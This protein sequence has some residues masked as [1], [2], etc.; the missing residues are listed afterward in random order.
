MLGVL[1]CSLIQPSGVP[2]P[3]RAFSH[4]EH[5]VGYSRA[6][7]DMHDLARRRIQTRFGWLSDHPVHCAAAR[8]AH[9]A[10]PGE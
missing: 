7:E 6:V 4:V 8:A 10:E 9:D 1:A 2:L 3:R 5:Q